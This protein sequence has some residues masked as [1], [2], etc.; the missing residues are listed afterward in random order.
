MRFLR[1]APDSHTLCELFQK[2][3]SRLRFSSA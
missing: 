1:I 2:N 3:T